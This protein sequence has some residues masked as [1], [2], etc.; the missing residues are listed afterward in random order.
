M[1]FWFVGGI[2]LFVIEAVEMNTVHFRRAS[3]LNT[4]QFFDGMCIDS[5]V[6]E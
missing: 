3:L 1:L 5:P 6:G 2:D 4:D